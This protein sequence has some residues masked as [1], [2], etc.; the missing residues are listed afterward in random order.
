MY[1]IKHKL[2]YRLIEIIVLLLLLYLIIVPFYYQKYI[3]INSALV[4]FIMGT[5]LLISNKL[6]GQFR[7]L[8]FVYN[9]SKKIF[10]PN[11]K[12]N[13]IIWGIFFYLIGLLSIFLP[14]N[15]NTIISD[16]S[17][18]NIFKEPLFWIVILLDIIIIYYWIRK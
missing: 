17:Y 15:S 16:F 18:L 9:I 2:I 13:H 10:F 4:L 12:Y 7:S 1:S 3:Q 6:K 5:I 11:T 8:N 14:S